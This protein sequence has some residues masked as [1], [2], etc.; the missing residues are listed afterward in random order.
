MAPGNPSETC[1][2]PGNEMLA[3]TSVFS[4][5]GAQ[6]LWRLCS[7]CG[8]GPGILGTGAQPGDRLWLQGDCLTAVLGT[9]G[10]KPRQ[11]KQEISARSPRQLSRC[12]YLCRC[13]YTLSP[14]EHSIKAAGKGGRDSVS[15]KSK[16]G[17][18]NLFDRT[19]DSFGYSLLHASTFSFLFFFSNA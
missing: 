2:L 17:L 14:L 15:G 16:L 5:T 10:F 7:I 11:T 18:W 8:L 13:L 9:G 19:F 6:Q 4:F 12:F 1:N 3:S